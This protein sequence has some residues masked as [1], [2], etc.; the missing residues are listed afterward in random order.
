MRQWQRHKSI[1]QDHLQHLHLTHLQHASLM[2]R[3]SNV[4]INPRQRRFV[5]VAFIKRN[6]KRPHSFGSGSSVRRTSPVIPQILVRL[7]EF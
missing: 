7:A 3:D 2:E 5:Q 6:C 1:T 4:K